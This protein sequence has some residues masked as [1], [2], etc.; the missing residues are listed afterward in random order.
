[1]PNSRVHV[2][3]LPQRIRPDAHRVVSR[4]FS[5]DEGQTRR[6]VARAMSIPDAQVSRILLE[7]SRRFAGVDG[8]LTSAWLEHFQRV[9]PYLPSDTPNISN[10]RSLLIGAYFTMHY[11]LEAAALFNPSI[12]ALPN[13]HSPGTTRFVMSLRAVGEGH[14]SSIVFRTGVIDADNTI[15]IH[16]PAHSYH[17]MNPVPNA[18]FDTSELRRTLQDLGRLGPLEE[19]ILDGVAE[20]FSVA[21]LT[22]V[23]EH[24]TSDSLEERDLTHTRETLLSLV[25][26][27]YRMQIPDDAD[28][29]E[30]AL[31]PSSSNESHGIE[32]LRMV[33]FTEDDGST[34]LYGTY[35]AY[36]GYSSFPSLFTMARD[37]RVIE[38]HTLVGESARNKGMALFPRMINGRYVMSARIDG[39]NLYVL[40]SDNITVW[41]DGRLALEP[42][43]WWEYAIIGNCGS[44]I[45][46]PEGWLLLTHGVGPMRQY[47]IGAALLD[48]DD[49]S[50]VIGRLKEP[51]ITPSSHERAGYVPNVVYSCG[52]MIHNGSLI[53]PYAVSDMTTTF[54]RVDL[55]E[56]LDALHG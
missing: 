39:E 44:P 38:S 1:M 8:S 18:E 10:E 13:H 56:L 5:G 35:T 29:S 6:R 43:Y 32:D 24:I 21:E 15:T 30:L 4:F 49:P 41:N 2:E 37:S 28:V 20:T 45:E 12:V 53:I 16:E 36:N 52:S 34:R 50:K 26:S 42:K 17:V 40:R 48:L 7:M 11:A 22:T 14:L 54:A 31:L 27:N 25:G 19:E 51:L 9:E 46:T 33:L 23:L 55:Q 47:S 3:H